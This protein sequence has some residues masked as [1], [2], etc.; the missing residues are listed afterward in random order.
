M[1]ERTDHS[2]D[3][4]RTPYIP[5]GRPLQ[6]DEAASDVTG[7]NVP[8][9]ADASSNIDTETSRVPNRTR[10]KI[11]EG[12]TTMSETIDE[13]QGQLNPQHLK[14]QGTDT[15]KQTS[16]QTNSTTAQK[17]Q[18]MANQVSEKAKPLVDQATTQARQLSDQ[19]QRQVRDRYQELQDRTGV[20]IT[21]DEFLQSPHVF[22][23]SVDGLVAK[24]QEQRERLGITSIMTGGYRTLAPVVERLA[25]T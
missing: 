7:G 12:N 20:E 16:I 4:E 14:A 13:M 18:Q 17:L 11:K 24:L 15:V 5:G 10:G 19:A 3:Y 9:D 1:A 22:I 6:G 8:A 21:L 2:G 25:G 23:G